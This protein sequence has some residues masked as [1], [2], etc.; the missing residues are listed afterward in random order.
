MNV[1][2]N[3]YYCRNFR[4]WQPPKMQRFSG[5]L[6]E[7][8]VNQTTGGLFQ[9]EVLTHL[10]PVFHGEMILSSYTDRVTGTNLNNYFVDTW[11]IFEC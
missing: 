4:K 2:T 8:Y 5:C 9:E 1:T 10:L 7:V 3:H 11:Y 6:Q